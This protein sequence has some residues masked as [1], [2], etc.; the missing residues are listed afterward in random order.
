MARALGVVRPDA[1]EAIRLQL[2]P[3]RRHVG[4]RAG[5]PALGHHAIGDPELLLDVMADLVR[6][7]VRLCEVAGGAEA[8]AQRA[9]EVEVEID[10]LVLR[11]VERPGGGAGDAARRLH[12]AV[13]ED[14]L[15]ISILAAHATE[16]RAP[17]VLGVGEHR[18]HEVTQVVVAAR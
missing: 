11:T 1:R 4:L 16:Q 3:D 17:G 12:G 2:Q 9:E 7:D 13:E 15:G 10:L 18:G 6:D 8:L 14:Q 5:A